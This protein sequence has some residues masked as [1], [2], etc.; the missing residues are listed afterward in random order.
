MPQ[1]EIPEIPMGLEGTFTTNHPFYMLFTH[2]INE[3]RCEVV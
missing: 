1:A 3:W 2:I